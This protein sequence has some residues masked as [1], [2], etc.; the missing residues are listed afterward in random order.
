MWLRSKCRHNML[1]RLFGLI[2]A[3]PRTISKLVNWLLNPKN[4][5]DYVGPLNRQYLSTGASFVVTIAYRSGLALYNFFTT[6]VLGS[7][8]YL[9]QAIGGIILDLWRANPSYSKWA[10][11]GIS[12][13]VILVGTYAF[14]GFKKILEIVH[15]GLT[16]VV[17]F[18]R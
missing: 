13:I 6:Y 10:Y 1:K 9:I 3:I 18:L 16:V 5:D 17:N 15:L 12:S 14:I 8:A 11:R 2:L 7:I 4:G